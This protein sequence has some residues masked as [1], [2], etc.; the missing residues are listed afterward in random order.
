MKTAIVLPAFNESGMI[1]R[2]VREV[3]ELYPL[4]IVVDDGSTDRTADRAREA[5]ATVA[6]HPLNRGQGAA[7]QTGMTLALRLGAE[8][9]VTFDSDGQHRVRDIDSLIAPIREGHA[10][11]VLGTRFHGGDA[12]VPAGRRLLL[13]CATLFTRVVS[14]ARV[15]DAHNG[16][17]AFSRRAA[18]EIEITMDRMAHASELID[19]VR[20]SGLAWV[21]VPVTVRY[22]EYSRN[23]GQR[24]SGA[25]R[26]VI[27][28]VLGRLLG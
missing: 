7:L 27:D 17:R 8:C 23:K 19:Q 5:G 14:G 12:E 2:V 21:E 6:R 26:I 11:I 18:R 13:R 24:A 20:R 3:R 28:Y 22:T 9:I 25:F 4:V 15:T 1:S 10:E 16:L